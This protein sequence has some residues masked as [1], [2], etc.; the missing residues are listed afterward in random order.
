MYVLKS[1]FSFSINV[2][3]T[4]GLDL[5]D[6]NVMVHQLGSSDLDWSNCLC[7][8]DVWPPTTYLPPQVNIS[9]NFCLFDQA[10]YLV[11]QQLKQ[12][13]EPKL[14]SRP[15]NRVQACHH[16]FIQAEY[17][18]TLI[19]QIDRITYKAYIHTG[20]FHSIQVGQW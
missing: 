19:L 4:L 10:K 7:A 17:S 13:Y 11:A 9:R 8:N 16:H 14:R 5:A 18:L 20:G 12:A 15:M 1:F 2:F 6:F 3:I